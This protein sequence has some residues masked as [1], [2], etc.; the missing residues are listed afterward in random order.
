MKYIDALDAKKALES[1]LSPRGK[2][3]VLEMTGQAGWEFAKVKTEGSSQDAAKLK[4]VAKEGVGRSRVLIIS[5][6]PPVLDKI[7]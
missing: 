5:D 4:R 3:T 6:I 1:Q 2:I 7:R